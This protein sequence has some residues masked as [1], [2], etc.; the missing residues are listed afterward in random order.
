MSL[1]IG[2][3]LSQRATPATPETD[4]TSL[5]PVVAATPRTRRSRWVDEPIDEASAEARA[6]HRLATR[7]RFRTYC[8]A[9]GR[10]TESA[11]ATAQRARC[12]QC[13]G[14]MLVEHMLG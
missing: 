14:T 13:G 11:M 2:G 9:C 3:A 8:M 1:I 4:D 7:L 5:P 6:A 12:E 10:S